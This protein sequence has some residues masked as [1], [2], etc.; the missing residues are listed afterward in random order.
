MLIEDKT[1][2]MPED[3]MLSDK[4]GIWALALFT[5]CADSDFEI[6][7]FSK[8]HENQNLAF[9]QKL[10]LTLQICIEKQNKNVY[11]IFFLILKKNM[12]CFFYSTV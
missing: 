12:R 1:D 9:C 8:V 4:S 3:K 7:N 6:H 5:H 11:K 10:K 2:K